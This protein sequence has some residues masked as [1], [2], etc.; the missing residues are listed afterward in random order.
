M[1]IKEEAAKKSPE[2]RLKGGGLPGS[3]VAKTP[4]FR[5][6]GGS[7]IS[8]LRTKILHHMW[9]KTLRKRQGLGVTRE[10]HKIRRLTTQDPAHT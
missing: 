4:D 9:P 6:G 10:A 5:A 3:P 8:G 2:A 7:L 1:L